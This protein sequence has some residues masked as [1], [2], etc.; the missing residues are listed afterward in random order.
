M[1]LEYVKEFCRYFKEEIILYDIQ[2]LY[3]IPE[4]SDSGDYFIKGLYLAKGDV[5]MFAFKIPDSIDLSIH[6][7]ANMSLVRTLSSLGHIR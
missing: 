3:F 2:D 4:S 7:L 5:K 6:D 1:D